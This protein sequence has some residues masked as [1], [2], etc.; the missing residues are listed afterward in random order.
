MKISTVQKVTLSCPQ[1]IEIEIP[2]DYEIN[3]VQNT[4]KYTLLY[5]RLDGNINTYL[6][7][8]ISYMD[9][10]VLKAVINGK[11]WRSFKTNRII[12]MVKY[13]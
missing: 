1:G 5:K 11:G 3:N 12:S 6:V 2:D 8:S 9:R 13:N 4:P 10:D 7:N